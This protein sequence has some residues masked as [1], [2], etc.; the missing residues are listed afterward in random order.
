MRV[1][2]VLMVA[3]IAGCVPSGGGGEDDSDAMVVLPATDGGS[4]AEDA[5]VEA[6]AS[7]EGPHPGLLD[8]SQAQEQAPEAFAVLFETTAGDF[9]VDVTRS[10]APL[11]ADRFYNLTRIG[12]YDGCAFFRVLEGFVAQTGISGDPAVS[13]AWVNAR[14]ADDP[15]L[16]SNMRGTVTFATAGPNTR[17]TQIFFNFRDNAALD[18]QGFAPF[19][20]VRDMAALEAL[21]A[22]YGEGAPQG[23]GPDQQRIYGEGNAY[24]EAS[25]PELDYIIRARPM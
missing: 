15:V 17:T 16:D 14:I 25:F 22:D 9:V 21:Y 10:W 5:G 12:Y 8:P 2:A 24:L 4:P 11:G 6:D 1:F 23:A 3:V 20:E 7:P 19:G 18:G 13:A